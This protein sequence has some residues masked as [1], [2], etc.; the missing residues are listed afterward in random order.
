MQDLY[1][2][3]PVVSF[4]NEQESKNDWRMIQCAAQGGREGME[5]F[6]FYLSTNY[7]IIR[8][9]QKSSSPVY[10]TYKMIAEKTVLIMLLS[11]KIL[12]K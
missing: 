12:K 4:R 10:R 2:L 5:F 7:L 1:E 6:A 3:V 8:N 11:K 9:E